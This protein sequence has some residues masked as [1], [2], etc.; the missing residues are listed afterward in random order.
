MH[1]MG[2]DIVR[3]IMDEKVWY[4]TAMPQLTNYREFSP[5]PFLAGSVECFWGGTMPTAP[6][7]PS[8]HRVLP[9]GC[10]DLLFDFMAT[11]SQ[12]ASVI[13]TM[14]RALTVAT[15]GP[16][17]LL[18]VRFRPGGFFGFFALDATELT[19]A[20]VD[21]TNFWGQL[22]QEA[23]HRL[24]EATSASR[25]E[26]LQEVLSARMNGRIHTDPFIHHCVA[27]IETACGSLRIG[28]L[29]KSTG[30]STRQLERKF[31]QR[32]GI[33][34]KTFARVVRFKGLEEATARRDPPDWA[35]LAGD[36]GF[37]DQSHLVREFKAFSGL[38]PTDYMAATDD[39]S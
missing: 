30:L 2:V 4:P 11:G 28:D 35:R 34:P 26:I 1:T 7:T 27:R 23:W 21:L 14:T 32:L 16:V 9:D 38:T 12:R 15:S 19:D 8:F 36:F 39:P 22:A 5:G 29:A 17:D 31:A 24:G 20:R 6:R 3:Q 13:G 37:A 10:M 33:S 18:G 25:I